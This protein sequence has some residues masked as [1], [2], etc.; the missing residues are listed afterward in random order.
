MGDHLNALLI[1]GT[2]V[3]VG[4]TLLTVAL[5]AYW[6]RYC[7]THPL[8]IFSPVQCGGHRELY[9]DELALGQTAE[10]TNPFYFQTPLVPPIAADRQGEAVSLKLLWQAFEQLTQQRD[11]VLIDSWGGFGSPLTNETTLAD[12]A[13]DWRLPTVLVVPVAPG[14]IAQAVANAALAKH[15]RV[16]L[17]GIILNCNHPR[18]RHE[19]EDWANLDLIQGLTN[20]PVLGCIPYLDQPTDLSKLV[21]VASNLNLERLL[22]LSR[23]T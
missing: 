14:A 12:W 22:P 4:K 3:G 7:S 6:Q 21:K 13:W 10:E 16:N 8:G 17:K 18:Q 15:A 19:V 5:A 1:A 11:F 9:P 20:Q 2:D 23:N